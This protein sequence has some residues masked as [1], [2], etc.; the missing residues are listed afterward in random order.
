[1]EHLLKL[2]PCFYKCL[3]ILNCNFLIIAILVGFGH[4]IRRLSA[5][6]VLLEFKECFS[7]SKWCF[8]SYTVAIIVVSL[9]IVALSSL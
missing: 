6:H 1:M 4:F 8:L 3:W 2:L 9:I 7:R 5:Y